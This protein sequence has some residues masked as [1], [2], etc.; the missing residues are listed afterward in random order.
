LATGSESREVLVLAVVADDFGDEPHA[1]ALSA[2]PTS[3]LA[4]AIR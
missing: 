3:T 2:S 4:S 1:V